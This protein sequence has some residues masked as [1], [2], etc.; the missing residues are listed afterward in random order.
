MNTYS[1]TTFDELLKEPENQ[2]C[3]DCGKTPAQWASVNNAVYLCISCS[4]NHRGYGVD[5]SY[6]RSTTLDTWSSNQMS[7]MRCGGNKKCDELLKVY[8][9]DK[10]KVDKQSLYSSKLMTFY[11]KY[12]KYKAVG[13]EIEE[14]PPKK[15]EALQNGNVNVGI[16]NNED[17][18]K[19][20]GS[21][22]M[23]SSSEEDENSFKNM[24]NVWMSKAYDSTKFIA[25]KVGELDIGGKVVSVGNAVLDKGTE[26]SKSDKVVS[27]AKKANDGLNYLIGRLFGTSSSSETTKTESTDN[28]NE[29]K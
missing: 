18:F 7:L 8:S 9:I 12:L 24:L 23:T 25:G 6:V 29:N 15:E 3:F 5:V 14:Q 28:T 1:N 2:V 22:G 26:I 13:Q 11:R 16:V 17:R 19:S 10:S 21:S 4:G 20:V 27:F